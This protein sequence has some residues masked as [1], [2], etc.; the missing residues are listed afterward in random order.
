MIAIRATAFTCRARSFSWEV[1]IARIS[2]EG[3]T[4]L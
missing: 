2:T 3:R 4:S 1:D